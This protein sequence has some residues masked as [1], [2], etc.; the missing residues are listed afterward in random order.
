MSAFIIT[1]T[2]EGDGFHPAYLPLVTR[3]HFV[4]PGAA[5]LT[6]SSRRLD[7]LLALLERDPAARDWSDPIPLDVY[8][9]RLALRRRPANRARWTEADFGADLQLFEAEKAERRAYFD[10]RA[11]T[12]GLY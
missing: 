3:A 6:V 8:E 1:A 10:A 9:A 5:E 7:A 2:I 4:R 12:L 11:A